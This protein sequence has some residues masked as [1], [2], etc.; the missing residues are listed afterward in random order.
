MLYII[1]KIYYMLC[2]L[3]VFAIKVALVVRLY[4]FVR[5]EC[6]SELV[7]CCVPMTDVLLS[8][9]VSLFFI[10][11]CDY[12]L[13]ISKMVSYVRLYVVDWLFIFNSGIWCCGVYHL[14]LIII[15]SWTFYLYFVVSSICLNAEYA[16]YFCNVYS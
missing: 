7:T 6:Y 5:A 8:W 14:Y 11:F 4:A 2:V 16:S 1:V 15:V 9:I 3:C 13:L 12:F 10:M